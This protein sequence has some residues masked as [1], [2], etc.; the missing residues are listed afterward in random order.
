MASAVASGCVLPKRATYIAIFFSK[1]D[2]N[3]NLMKTN[4]DQQTS[5]IAATAMPSPFLFLGLMGAFVAPC[6]W[7]EVNLPRKNYTKK[8]E[9]WNQNANSYRY[10]MFDFFFLLTS[11]RCCQ[12]WNFSGG[13]FQ[14]WLHCNFSWCFPENYLVAKTLLRVLRY[15]TLKRTSICVSK[16]ILFNLRGLFIRFNWI[17]FLCPLKF[18]GD[19][20]CIWRCMSFMLD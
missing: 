7:I 4:S 15:L 12:Y 5:R 8:Q 16:I 14:I 3:S 2:P 19:C 18:L 9:Q 11:R 10:V 13:N 20:F 6:W 17:Y 1:T